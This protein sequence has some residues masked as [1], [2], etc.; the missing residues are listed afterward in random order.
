MSQ[1]PQR[2]EKKNEVM[3]CYFL[4][5]IL[6]TIYLCVISSFNPACCDHTWET[7]Q[8]GL[9]VKRAHHERFCPFPRM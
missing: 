7:L 6:L 8:D 2:H 1:C 3:V 4:W 5:T 9:A